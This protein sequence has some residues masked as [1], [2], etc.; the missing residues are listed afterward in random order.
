MDIAG[1]GWS[2]DGAS[3]IVVGAGSAGYESLRDDRQMT[4]KHTFDGLTDVLQQVPSIGDLLSLGCGFGGGLG[5]RPTNR[6]RLT[7][8]MPG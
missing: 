7:N 2:R 6:S 1:S 5:S 8:S 4:L 3:A